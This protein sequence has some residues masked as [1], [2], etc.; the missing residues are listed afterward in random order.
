MR[1]ALEQWM[2]T[3]SHMVVPGDVAR[4][5]RERMNPERRKLVE[6]VMSSSRALPEALAYQLLVMQDKTD[7]P[8]ATSGLIVQPEGLQ[9]KNR[10]A[11]KAQ[12]KP[13]PEPEPAPESDPDATVIGAR[14]E[15]SVSTTIPAPA[16]RPVQSEDE[17]LGDEEDLSASASELAGVVP[18]PS[19]SGLAARLSSIPPQF[20][21]GTVSVWL[22]WVMALAMA[23][24]ALAY[25]VRQP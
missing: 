19:Q 20:R 25:S 7:T 14:P 11:A 24:S 18:E 2:L 4:I 1:I 8:T 12:P 17:S 6:A 9:K 21:S 10:Q 15:P 3:S 23:I 5:V 16:P 13:E 22:F